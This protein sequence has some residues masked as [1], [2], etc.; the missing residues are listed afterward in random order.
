MEKMETIRRL[1]RWKIAR[2]TLIGLAT[3]AGSNLIAQTEPT[4]TRTFIYS[5]KYVC[6]DVPVPST[7]PCTT[8]GA[9]R[10]S[11]GRECSSLRLDERIKVG[12][13]VIEAH[14]LWQS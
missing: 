12:I 7:E 8:A 13:K 10:S 3:V 1:T 9:C 14:G 5:A 11:H 4:A 6:K 2:V